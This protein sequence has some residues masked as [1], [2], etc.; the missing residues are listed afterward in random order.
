M[1]HNKRKTTRT[2]GIGYR[3]RET[4]WMISGY[5]KHQNPYGRHNMQIRN[6]SEYSTRFELLKIAASAILTVSLILLFVLVI[7]LLL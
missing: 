3:I 4:V 1:E 7:H 2:G 6:I 5:R